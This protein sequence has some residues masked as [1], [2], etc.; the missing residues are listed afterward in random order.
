MDELTDIFKILSD[1]TRLRVIVLLAQEKL[2]VCQM[3]GI[4]DTSQPKVSKCLSKLRDMKLVEDERKDKFV[5]YY[6]KANN[7]VLASILQYT[8]EHLS[9]YPQLVA[10]KIKL[11]NKENYLTQCCPP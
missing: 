4:L 5:Y 8:L 1:E 7:E 6:L 9:D 10:D 11:S 3:S 2:C